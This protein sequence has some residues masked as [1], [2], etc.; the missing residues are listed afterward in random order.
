MVLP[1]AQSRAWQ[2][3]LGGKIVQRTCTSLS[4]FKEPLENNQRC[5]HIMLRIKTTQNQSEILL[6]NHCYVFSH[7]TSRV[8]FTNHDVSAGLPRNVSFQLTQVLCLTCEDFKVRFNASSSGHAHSA[9]KTKQKNKWATTKNGENTSL[10]GDTAFWTLGG[11]VRWSIVSRGTSALWSTPIFCDLRHLEVH[12]LQSSNDF[13]VFFFSHHSQTGRRHF[14]R[15]DLPDHDQVLV[16]KARI[17]PMCAAMPESSSSVVL[18]VCTGGKQ[19]N[20]EHAFP[21]SQYGWPDG[22]D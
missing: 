12:V 20:D 19:Q 13:C 7:N 11:F 18:N 9:H 4:E 16:P 6:G 21:I 10:K 3:Q 22:G 5:S 1:S 2:L 8:S 15:Q 17:A 14:D